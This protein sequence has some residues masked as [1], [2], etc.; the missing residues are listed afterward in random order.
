M[1]APG[2]PRYRRRGPRW[3]CRLRLL[4][5][6]LLMGVMV[7]STALAG[8]PFVWCTGMARARLSCC[9]RG[10]HPTADTGSEH[11]EPAVPACEAYCCEGRRVAS[12]PRT[13]HVHRDITILPAP[14][15]AVLPVVLY[16]PVVAAPTDRYT[17][18]HG[19]LAR[20]GPEPP[21][22]ELNRT[23]LC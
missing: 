14:L 4:A 1:F 13:D 16:L 11:R 22:F 8:L 7:V 15:V 3:Q 9:C 17:R 2:R 21:L 23:Y 19:R 6:S 20:A 5:V 18:A 12:L 10:S